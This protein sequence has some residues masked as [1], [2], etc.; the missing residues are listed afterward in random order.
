MEQPHFVFDQEKCVGCSACAIACMNENGSGASDPW[1]NIHSSNPDQV[2]GIVTRYLS[3]AC[4]H[5]ED[6]PCMAQCP[7]LAYRRDAV[8]GA[9]LHLAENCIGC[10]Y[11]TWACPYD[12]PKYNPDK[13]IVEKCHFC[14]HLLKQG[15]TPACAAGCPT[16]ALGISFGPTERKERS[17][18]IPVL[19][20]IG[21]RMLLIACADA[22]APVTDPGLLM[23]FPPI[24]SRSIEKKISATKEWPLL[25]FTLLLATLAGL[26]WSGIFNKGILPPYAFL[27]LGFVAALVSTVHLG[28][29]LRAWRAILNLRS[30][31]VSR[32]I[33]LFGL[34]VLLFALNWLWTPLPDLLVHLTGLLMLVSVDLLYGLA[35]WR[36][37]LRIHSAETLFIASTLYALISATVWLGL[38]LGL[39]RTG[40]YIAWLVRQR[41]AFRLEHFIRLLCL[42][43]A[44]V[45]VW[46]DFGHAY[47]FLFFT[48]GEIIDRTHFYDSLNVPDPGEEFRRG[49]LA[50]HK[51]Y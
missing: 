51:R 29:P 41:T 7:A 4:N 1:R 2:P 42:W 32:E 38:I 14:D 36:W 40:V 46:I 49:Y 11:C 39:I 27:V 50:D 43:S 30:S 34:F 22:K 44:I 19:V 48:V 8:T 47:A 26:E 3:M 24:E 45:L 16:G 6:A 33:A 37:P 15:L 12:A 21:P 35:R 25:T 10:R 23:E 20:D 5:C 17:N 13:G 31:K 18:L 9:V 28:K